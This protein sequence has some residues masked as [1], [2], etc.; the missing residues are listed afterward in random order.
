[1][2]GTD[3]SWALTGSGSWAGELG[4]IHGL[5][6]SVKKDSA[7]AHSPP[8]SLRGVNGPARSEISSQLPVGLLGAQARSNKYSLPPSQTLPKKVQWVI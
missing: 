6:A 8:S 2:L 7:A 1:M 4:C 3:R 5:R